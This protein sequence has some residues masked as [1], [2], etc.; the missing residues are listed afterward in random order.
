MKSEGEGA[1]GV[2]WAIAGPVGLFT[3]GIGWAVGLL[4]TPIV[5][6]VQNNKNKKTRTESMAYTNLV[7]IGV[8]NP[9]E[10]IQVKTL[11]PIGSQP[12][13]KITVMDNKKDLHVITK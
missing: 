8:L 7:P 12:Q 13:L 2:T 6:V 5:W 3:L 11:V 4:A 9:A 1:I 10:S